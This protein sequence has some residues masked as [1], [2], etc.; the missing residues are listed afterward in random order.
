MGSLI[1][2]IRNG[3]G[4]ALAAGRVS[5]VPETDGVMESYELRIGALEL[6]LDANGNFYVPDLPDGEYRLHVR[7]W[8]PPSQGMAD[9]VSAS[10]TVSGPTDLSEAIALGMLTGPHV[11]VIALDTDGQPYYV[12]GGT[13]THSVFIDSDGQPYYDT[14]PGGEDV[15][16]DIDGAPVILTLP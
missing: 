4:A 8:N 2:V 6:T 7:F 13:G 11:T 1:G 12:P 3:V 10:F 9:L 14:G 15:Y 5:V 16:Q